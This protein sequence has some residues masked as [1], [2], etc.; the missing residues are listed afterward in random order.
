MS[1]AH[2]AVRR[3][4]RILVAVLAG[5][6][7]YGGALAYSLGG[8]Q[9]Y[10]NPFYRINIPDSPYIPAVVSGGGYLWDSWGLDGAAG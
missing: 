7:V 6:A 2:A 8:D 4:H 9:L 5:T 1:N 10:T 3:C